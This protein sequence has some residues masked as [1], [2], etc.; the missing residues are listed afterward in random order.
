MPE[1]L[2]VLIMTFGLPIDYLYFNAMCKEK[3]ECLMA[4]ARV[5]VMLPSLAPLF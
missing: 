5:R 4:G 2:F 1:G 3:K